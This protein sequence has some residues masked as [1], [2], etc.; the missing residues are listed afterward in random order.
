M[1]IAV[2]DYTLCKPRKCNLECIRF[3]PVNRSR[4]GSKAIEIDASK[5]KPVI[6]EESCIGCNICVK[7][8]PFN[9]I[10]IV[11]IPD[12]LGRKTVHRYGRNAFKLHG[13]PVPKK[14]QITGIIGKNG[15]GKTTSIKILAGE[16]KPNL[17]DYEREPSWDEI[18]GAFKGSELQT[19]FEKLSQG[20]LRT[21]H[22]TQYIDAVPRLV[23]GDVKTLLSKA[24]ERGLWRELAE[25][26]GLNTIYDREIKYLSGGELQK[27]LII[28]VITKQAD[29]YIF[30]EPSSYLDVRERI[31]ISK[32]IR[33]YTPNNSYT[34][35][36]EHDLAVLDYLSD[37][38]S[39]IYGEPGVYGIVS[40]PYGTRTGINNF[41]HG[42]LPAEN[43][44]LRKEPIIFHARGEV[45]DRLLGGEKYVEWKNTRLEIDGFTLTVHEGYIRRGEVIGILG[46]NGIGKTTFVK[47]VA[48]MLSEEME[49][50]VEISYK[51]QYVSSDIFE[52]K[53]VG[54]AIINASQYAMTPGNWIYEEIIRPFNLAK[55][56][57]RSIA[58]L[59]GGELQKLAVA[60][61]L[62]RE[63]DVYLLDEPSA[64]LDVEERLRVAKIIRRLTESRGKA[65]FVVEHDVS[66]IDYVC[67]RIMVFTGQ[68]GVHGIAN[69]P[70]G[71][72]EGMN[73]FLRQINVTFRRDPSTGRPRINK[74]DSYLDRMQKRIGEYYY[75]PR[76]E[77]KE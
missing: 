49:E 6:Y 20:E 32:L 21:V 65:A 70:A 74:E 44:R 3:C 64:Y 37:N 47:H 5:G 63:A 46:P 56:R 1:R 40:K 35:V 26:V 58:S 66:I 14:G 2:I 16:L 39:I 31:R 30:D 61:T 22:K 45:G 60:V 43:I 33:E 17:G 77:E 18:I 4:R 36:V 76:S 28:A 25:E 42:Y 10:S 11:N 68:P 57:E 53:R 54:D 62:A 75:V 72:R 48:E 19:Y 34:L 15:T 13:L 7:K 59:S 55:Y 23:K 67:D 8:C 29:V 27:L 51:P 12:E 38:V 24:D 69:P 50:K 9:A 41:L 52:E 71:L 73:S